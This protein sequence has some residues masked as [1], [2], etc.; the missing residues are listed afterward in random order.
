MLLTLEVAHYCVT[1]FCHPSFF[2]FLPMGKSV[3]DYS[4]RKV[5]LCIS[6]AIFQLAFMK[7]K[8]PNKNPQQ[9]SMSNNSVALSK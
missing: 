2:G 3:A 4:M 9:S 1:Q 7:N 6:L 5:N 8:D